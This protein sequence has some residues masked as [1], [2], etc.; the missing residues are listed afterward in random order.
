[1]QQSIYRR[2]GFTLIELLVVIAIIAILA[3]ILFPVFARARENARRASCMSNLKQIGLGMM[4]YVQDYDGKYFLRTYSSDGAGAITGTIYSYWSPRAKAGG[5]YYPW[6]LEP[7]IKSTQL[8]VCPSNRSAFSSYAYNGYPA[9]TQYTESMIDAPSQM[10]AIVDDQFGG[11]IAYSPN[12]TGW[13]SNFC[14]TYNTPAD[15]GC[16][17]DQKF[18]GRHLDGVNI[19]FMDGHVKWLRPVTLY[20]NGNPDPYYTGKN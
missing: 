11:G 16:P 10:V 14:E 17:T 20:N 5:G 19:A 13:N 1:M 2:N 18:Y 6:V 15:P 12:G 9:T 3:A 4:M 7:Y 8:F